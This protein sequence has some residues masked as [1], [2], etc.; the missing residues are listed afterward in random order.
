[1]IIKIQTKKKI[2]NIARLI[3]R[4]YFWCILRSEDIFVHFGYDYYMYIGCKKK[5]CDVIKTIE[6]TGL[7]VEPFESPYNKEESI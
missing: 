3:L 2:E 4:S 7:F 1:M 6:K 5:C